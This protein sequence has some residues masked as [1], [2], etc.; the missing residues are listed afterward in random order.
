[1]KI[2]IDGFKIDNDDGDGRYQDSLIRHLIKLDCKNEYLILLPN[3]KDEL[4]GDNVKQTV[5][6][7]KGTI[8]D[9]SYYFFFLKN[10]LKKE[11]VDVCH[12]TWSFGTCSPPCPVVSTVHDLFSLTF[13]KLRNN[14]RSFYQ[15]KYLVPLLLGRSDQIISVSAATKTDIIRYYGISDRKINVIHNGIDNQ[16]FKPNFREKKDI[17]VNQIPI[18]K[19]YLLFVGYVTPKKNLITLI[20]AL[21]ILKKKNLLQRKLVIV[22]NKGD[23]YGQFRNAVQSSNL[24]GDVVET[25]FVTDTDLAKL[26]QNA[27]AFVF[28]SI[29]EGFGF[30]LIEAMASGVPVIHSDI[31]VF[32]EIS[33]ANSLTFK[34]LNPEDCSEKI[35]SLEADPVLYER[36]K[37][38]G[39]RLSTKFF[40]SNVTSAYLDVYQKACRISY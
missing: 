7:K 8:L 29:N 31:A 9:Q 37:K 20:R 27:F 10:L 13:P 2:A 17:V 4:R 39:I 28:P 12:L 35:I 15:Y 11:K 40:W 1:M 24:T 34:P 30:P 6:R 25:G 38:T 23:G 5:I 21:A 36:L 33:Q 18:A 32:N 19:G 22:G 16:I 3:V 26:Y 14:P